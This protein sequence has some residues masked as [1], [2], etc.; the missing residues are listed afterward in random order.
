MLKKLEASADYYRIYKGQSLQI[1]IN[2]KANEDQ[3]TRVRNAI[4]LL[5]HHKI[6]YSFSQDST[7]SPE[8]AGKLSRNGN[9]IVFLGYGDGIE[10]IRK[11]GPEIISYMCHAKLETLLRGDRPENMNIPPAVTTILP[12]INQ[13]LPLVGKIVVTDDLE[14]EIKNCLGAGTL[15]FDTDQLQFGAMNEQTEAEINTHMND[16][17]EKNG[18]FKPRKHTGETFMLRIKGSPISACTFFHHPNADKSEMIEIGKLWA[19]A[20]RNGL[21]QYTLHHA[22]NYLKKTGVAAD[23]IFAITKERGAAKTFTDAGYTMESL[24]TLQ[25]TDATICDYLKQYKLADDEDRN[26]HRLLQFPPDPGR[27]VRPRRG[28]F[29]SADILD[30]SDM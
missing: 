9:Q 21:S 5:L 2:P 25:S 8:A 29:G 16:Y 30:N 22:N 4:K 26:V 17:Y 3:V 14:S 1:Q 18:S 24:R 12:L 6:S 7:Q 28:P 11:D 20:T 13:L 19:G 27:G 23:K 15:F 10:Q